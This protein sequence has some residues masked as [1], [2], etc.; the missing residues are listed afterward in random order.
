MKLSIKQLNPLSGFYFLLILSLIFIF[1]N[2]AINGYTKES[3]QITEWLIN[4]QGGF[5]RRGLWGEVLFKLYNYFELSPY[6]TIIFVCILAFLIFLYFFIFSFI[7][8]GYSLYILPFCFFLGAPIVNDFWVRKDI[9]LVLIFISIIYLSI[10]NTKTNLI[11]IN[12]LFIMGVLTHEAIG[13][14]CLPIL[15]LIKMNLRENKKNSLLKSLIELSPSMIAF[16]L[17]LYNK[18]STAIS[19]KIWN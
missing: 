17:C 11:L 13:F 16:G 5:V 14:F 18:G 7:K 2:K 8:N 12:L 19:S 15:L 6:F 9:L 3:W 10:K 1:L 4:Y